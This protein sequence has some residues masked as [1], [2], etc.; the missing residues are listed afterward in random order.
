ML[1]IN[2]TVTLNSGHEMPQL[3]FGVFEVDDGQVCER[4]VLAA[5]EAGYRHV[6][7]AAIYG[8]EAS[9]GRALAATDVPREE[10][11]LT[12][13][14]FIRDLGREQTRAACEASLKR[15][16]TDYVDLYLIHWPIRDV[17]V[18][19][20]E[21]MQALR[22]EGKIRSIGV[23]NFT[24][25]RFEESFLP[26]VS[27]VPAVNQIE[28]HPFLY[29]TELIEFCRAKGIQPEAYSPLVRAQK[30]DHPTL[31][32]IAER[33][34]KSV[35]QVL[36]RWQLQQGIVVIPKSVHAERIRENTQVFDF[37]LSDDDMGALGSLN[38]DLYTIT[39]R[40]EDDW[41]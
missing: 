14:V 15:L 1:D 8:N 3:G 2:S 33:C 40:P 16:G 22:D 34:G 39:W 37:E 12:T 24:V 23:S 5:L 4:A 38:E 10:I 35:A 32:G 25:Q 20:W 17:I 7:T 31:K 27:E 19:T 21:T 26:H 36:I 29:R 41:V 6:D 28:L 13:K 18:E 9:V 30:M 11:F